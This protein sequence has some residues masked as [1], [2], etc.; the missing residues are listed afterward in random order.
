MIL[1]GSLL[2]KKNASSRMNK[3]KKEKKDD[4]EEEEEEAE[5]IHDILSFSRGCELF[6]F[7]TFKLHWIMTREI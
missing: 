3:K 4:E 6:Q 7:N 1:L 2:D 5:E